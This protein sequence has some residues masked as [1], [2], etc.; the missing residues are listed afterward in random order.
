MRKF[1]YSMMAV[2]LGTAA[3]ASS[4]ALADSSNA[5]LH[6]RGT[7]CEVFDGNG[8]NRWVPYDEVV[9]NNH[10]ELICSGRVPNDAGVTVHYDSNGT[11]LQYECAVGTVS[12]SWHETV[13]ASGQA[14]VKVICLSNR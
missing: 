6:I 7:E 12:T 1:V 14:T 4:V 11:G 13:S 8:N 9:N 5:A 3:I 2:G 10:G